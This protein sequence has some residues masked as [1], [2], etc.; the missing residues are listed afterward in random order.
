[1]SEPTGGSENY[2]YLKTKKNYEQSE[3]VIHKNNKTK[4]EKQKTKN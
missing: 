3:E 4:N 2:E 1:M